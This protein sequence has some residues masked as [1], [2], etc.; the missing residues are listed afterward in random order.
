LSFKGAPPIEGERSFYASINKAIAKGEHVDALNDII[1]E[2]DDYISY[3]SSA[4]VNDEPAYEK[5]FK[6]HV[7]YLLKKPV[8]REFEIE[9]CQSLEEL[10]E[11]IIDS[12]GWDNDHAHAFFFPKK[13]ERGDFMDFHSPYSVDSQYLGND[14]Y[15]TYHSC[16][17]RIAEIDYKKFPMINFVFDFGDGHQFSVRSLGIR[18]ENKSDFMAFMPKMIDQRGVGPEQYP[19]IFE[20]GDA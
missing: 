20:D 16:N 6:F 19:N 10:A 5:I 13:M 3:M 8:W 2:F 18:P 9:G 14:Q 12:M 17:I 11:G 1:K 7:E 15:P 4:F